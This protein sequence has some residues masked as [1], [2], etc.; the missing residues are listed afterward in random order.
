MLEPYAGSEWDVQEARY[1]Q[2]HVCL[3]AIYDRF[4]KRFDTTRAMA[5]GASS[6]IAK[7]ELTLISHRTNVSSPAPVLGP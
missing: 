7:T 2:Q 1:M 3:A 4:L 6:G 5:A